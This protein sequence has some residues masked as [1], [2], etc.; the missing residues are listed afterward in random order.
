MDTTHTTSNFLTARA[1]LFFVLFTIVYAP[2]VAALTGTVTSE[3]GAPIAN[4][5]VGLLSADYKN[6]GYALSNA[7]GTFSFS[8]APSNGFLYVQPKAS[9]NVQGLGVYPYQPRMYVLNGE[10]TADIQLPATG[11]LVLYGY[12]AAGQLMRWNDYKAKGKVGGQFFY[13]A[14]M[15]DE[16]VEAACW[17]VFDAEAREQGSP[18]S[19]GLPGLV[20]PANQTMSVNLLFWE[21]PGYGKLLLKADNFGQGFSL[22]AAGQAI[23]VEVNV[24]LAATA[25]S[26]L[27]RRKASLP[28][29]G[30]ASITNL[31]SL[32]AAAEALADPVERAAAA[33]AVLYSALKLRDDLELQAARTA[34]QTVRKGYLKVVVKK[35]RVAQSNCRVVIKQRDHSFKFGSYH[36][37]QYNDTAYQA[38][39]TAGFEMATMLFGWRWLET[40]PGVLLKPSH[41]DSYYGVTAAQ[42]LG[43]AVKAHGVVWMNDVVLPD[44]VYTLSYPDVQAQCLSYQQNLIAALGD[45]IK[46][47]E[48]INEPANI[49]D[50][51]MPRFAMNNM[52]ALAASNIKAV[53]GLKSLVNSP[54][55]FDFG[56]KYTYY[57]LDNQ[58]LDQFTQGYLEFLK[59]A[60]TEGVL[61]DVDSIGLHFYPGYKLDERWN[62]AEGP[63]M[64]PSWLADTLD[65][66]TQFGKPIHITEFSVPSYYGEDWNNGY[67]REPWTETTQADY[68][69]RVFTMAFANPNVQSLTWWDM[70]D[71][72]CSVLNAGLLDEWG[73]Q[74]AA[75]TRIQR[76]LRTSWTTSSAQGTTTSSGIVTLR[77]FG[78]TYDVTITPPSGS[79]ITKQVTITE[80][81][82]T[83][84]NIAL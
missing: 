52:T 68:A 36:G 41:I 84:L 23:V 65:R 8:S 77:G 60:Q 80:R 61:N 82:T 83:T 47:W 6:L 31:N 58:P 49:N 46:L 28:A 54:H 67:W 27:N 13:A 48:A 39:R 24:E 33:D 1:G 69:E 26:D 32:L 43:F 2:F 22:S 16:V 15:E 38:A 44:R 70:L 57:G 40:D 63:A 78:G 4:T 11:C 20:V 30:A 50:V 81:T 73:N 66:Y 62:Y 21:V 10:A 35:G 19:M 3:A 42:N 71:T 25:V 76:L 51:N 64:T 79:S 18:R 37:G 14:D 29:S 5:Y 45:K 17:P 74:K 7:Q 72:N 59:Q 53:P 75:Y 34:L 9:V 55:E 56:A 12:D